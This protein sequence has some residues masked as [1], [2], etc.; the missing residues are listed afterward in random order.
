M[1][2]M[3]MM[4]IIFYK[5]VLF[6]FPFWSILCIQCTPPNQCFGNTVERYGHANK[7]SIEFECERRNWVKSIGQSVGEINATFSTAAFTAPLHWPVPV[8]TSHFSSSSKSSLSLSRGI[9]SRCCRP[10]ARWYTAKVTSL[11][12][13][14]ITLWCPF[15]WLHTSQFFCNFAHEVRQA[16]SQPGGLRCLLC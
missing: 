3:M 11:L 13:A 5:I 4:M 2:M 1:M 8:R 10:C 14:S 16:H 12:L 7:P 15:S 9:Y 6:P